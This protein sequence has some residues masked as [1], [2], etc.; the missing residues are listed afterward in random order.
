MIMNRR[1]VKGAQHGPRYAF[2]ADV[3]GIRISS[4]G[5]GGIASHGKKPNMARYM[6]KD[7]DF[8]NAPSS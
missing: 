4:A 8:Y 2:P 6:G 7:A 3:D 5:S 1:I